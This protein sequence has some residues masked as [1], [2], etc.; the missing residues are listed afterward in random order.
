[1]DNPEKLKKLEKEFWIDRHS[2]AVVT[3]FTVYNAQ[4]NLFTIATLVAE[5]P[6]TGGVIPFVNI[7]TARLYNFTKD[8]MVFIVACECLFVLYILFFSY[9]ELRK[10]Y[11]E[12]SAHFKQFW[13]IVD[14]VIVSSAGFGIGLY[15]YRLLKYTDV[16]EKS[17]NAPFQFKSF[18]LAGYWDEMYTLS[19]AILVTFATIKLNK[20]LRFNKR[21]SLLSSTLKNA[22]FSLMMFG[23][24]FG[25]LFLAFTLIGT[26]VFGTA[27][28]GYRKSG[29]AFTSLLS[30]ML[31][32]TSFLEM[33]E[34]NRVLGP[35][36]FFCFMFLVS[37]VLIN[38]FLSI[39]I[40]S[41]HEVK[42]DLEKQ[43]NEYEIVDFIIERFKMWSGIGK[44]EKPVFKHRH[45]RWDVVESKVKS[46]NALTGGR[47]DHVSK[48][49]SRIEKLIERT[50]LLFTEIFPEKR[51]R[52]TK[53][54]RHRLPKEQRL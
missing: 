15:I 40:D 47:V 26:V 13:N 43:N 10:L 14:L 23:L 33:N 16:L 44:A 1:M 51:R 37:M 54:M 2:R 5:F 30:L 39:I 9:K 50:D 17:R 24:I 48:L 36:Y 53:A 41:Y 8:Y 34:A 42:R 12:G 52:P 19:I 27:V 35:V 20:L 49:E 46:L 31:G 4:T 22:A 7:Q 29:S 18:Q 32:K 3:E 25:I 38:L 28:R 6:A 11:K 21:M 45:V